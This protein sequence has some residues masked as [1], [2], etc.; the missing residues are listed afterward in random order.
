M[1]RRKLKYTRGVTLESIWGQSGVN[2]HH[3]T[4]ATTTKPLQEGH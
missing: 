2:L 4:S 3:P 1:Q